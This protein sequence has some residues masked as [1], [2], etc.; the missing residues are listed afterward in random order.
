[1]RSNLHAGRSRYLE[2][3]APKVNALTE[4]LIPLCCPAR[5]RKNP[6]A[7]HVSW[8]TCLDERL[9]GDSDGKPKVFRDAAVTNLQEFFSRFRRLSIGS[10]DSLERLVQ[11]A[12]SLIGGMVPDDLRQANPLRERISE[13]LTRIE[14]SLDGYMTER[15]RRNII[16]RAS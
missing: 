10:D 2:Q 8:Y 13:G 5:I 14:A 7:Y 11:Q 16:R 6:K 4:M 9:S 1:M 15:P 3:H 12:Q